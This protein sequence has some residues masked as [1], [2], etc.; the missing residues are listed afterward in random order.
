[1]NIQ[2]SE[3]NREVEAVLSSPAKPAFA[4][5]EIIVHANGRDYKPIYVEDVEVDHN[6]MARWH[7]IQSV[8]AVFSLSVSEYHLIPN[9]SAL[10]ITLIRTPLTE[11]ISPVVNNA[12]SKSAF[13]YKATLYSN[14][15]DVIAGNNPL[16]QTEQTAERG[17]FK[18]L[19]FQLVNPHLDL[20]LKQTVGG[21]F[22]ETSGINLIRYMLVEYSRTDEMD[23]ATYVK[24]CNLAP[25]YNENVLEHIEI[26][27]LTPVVDVPDIIHKNCGGVY[28]AGF[29]HY[30]WGPHWYLFSPYD[31]KA[32]EK[33]PK[34]LTLVNIPA[35]R[36]SNVERTY[37]TTDTQ[38][39]VLCTG[40]TIPSD[41][42]EQMQLNFGN[43]VRFIDANKVMDGFV[44]VDENKAI[45]DKSK[46]ANEFLISNR[47]SGINQ[48]KQSPR[49]ITSAK[50]LE[51]EELAMRM[52]FIVQIVWEH[53][54]ASLLYPGIPVKFMFSQNNVA[55]QLQGI[56]LG[57][58]TFHL[59]TTNNIS[60]NR[61]VAK[62]VLTVFLQR[63]IVFSNA[64][65]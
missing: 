13:R 48:I 23:S 33:S 18:S 49:R 10:E 26:P 35:N 22:R 9:R 29:K 16:L 54:D 64:V 20:L 50:F 24:G 5:W 46:V 52:G 45:I 15:S 41:N 28:P 58:H 1:M 27:H 39:I 2:Q 25:N 62:T 40:D 36:L 19:K 44:L 7:S 6:F 3:I 56:L 38:I 8:S 63:D 51:Y 4:T 32:Y 14:G 31:V 55:E 65:V 12:A 59:K 37:R 21:M 60:Q 17:G 30:L 42:S 53:S 61:F 57:C 11:S 34:T 43:G 47:K